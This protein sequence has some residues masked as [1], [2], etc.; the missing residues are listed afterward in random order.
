MKPD[1]KSQT[2]GTWRGSGEGG[3]ARGECRQCCEQ[4]GSG[5][6]VTDRKQ[7]GERREDTEVEGPRGKER[8]AERGAGRQQ[9]RLEKREG[10]CRGPPPRPWPLVL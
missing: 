10:D 7:P 2:P 4:E 6:R 9:L 5:H 1:S 3:Y 8:L